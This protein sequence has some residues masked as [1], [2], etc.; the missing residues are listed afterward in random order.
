MEK[1]GKYYGMNL[2]GIITKLASCKTYRCR[3]LEANI[4]WNLWKLNIV[5]NRNKMHVSFTNLLKT[6]VFCTIVK[7]IVIVW[8]I[9]I[10]TFA[11]NCS[12]L[13]YIKCP[14]ILYKKNY[15]AMWT[16]GSRVRQSSHFRIK[17]TIVYLLR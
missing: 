16:T 12:P 7:A 15:A 4:H 6:V 3:N 10:S 2:A 17:S 9:Y 1:F 13:R 8:Q 11:K 5:K 14:I